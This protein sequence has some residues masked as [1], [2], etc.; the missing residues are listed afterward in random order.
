MAPKYKP[1]FQ[2]DSSKALFSAQQE[3]KKQVNSPLKMKK[4][5]YN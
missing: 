4:I 1:L 2:K 5:I 3:F